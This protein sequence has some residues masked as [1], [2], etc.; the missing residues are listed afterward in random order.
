M[1]PSCKQ[2][3]LIPFQVATLGRRAHLLFLSGEA[4]EH[5]STWWWGKLQEGERC[6]DLG[7]KAGTIPL[8]RQWAEEFHFS[9]TGLRKVKQGHFSAWLLISA[10]SAQGRPD[11]GWIIDLSKAMYLDYLHCGELNLLSAP[12][13]TCESIQGKGATREIL[14]QWRV[15]SSSRS[16]VSVDCL[17]FGSSVFLF[18]CLCFSLGRWCGW[19]SGGR[20]KCP[21]K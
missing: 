11:L 1:V 19:C 7:R 15:G 14:E 17:F 6:E 2:L 21:W 13:S 9:F 5:G 18:L 20:N 10:V 8:C 4:V 12:L 3:I 16:D